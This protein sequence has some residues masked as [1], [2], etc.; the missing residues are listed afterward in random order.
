VNSFCGYGQTPTGSGAVAGLTIVGNDVTTT[1]ATYT[2]QSATTAA[3]LMYT[4]KC[5]WVAWAYALAPT[6]AVSQS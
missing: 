4:G 1:A 6:F 3:N 5:T 2:V